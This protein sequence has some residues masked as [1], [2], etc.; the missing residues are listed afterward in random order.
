MSSWIETY[1]LSLSARDS[2]TTHPSLSYIAPYTRYAD[3]YT[4]TSQSTSSTP[5][6]TARQA[7]KI[8][9]LEQRLR[10]REEELRGKTRLLENTQDEIVSLTLQLNMAEEMAEKLRGENEELVRRWME[11]MGSEAERMNLGSGF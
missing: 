1:T 10:D 7:A 5:Q 8:K 11:R 2:L 6:T 4:A 9:D 3:H